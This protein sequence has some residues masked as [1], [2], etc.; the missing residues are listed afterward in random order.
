MSCCGQCGVSSVSDSSLFQLVLVLKVYSCPQM[1]SLSIN[2]RVL[3]LSPVTSGAIPPFFV[4]FGFLCCRTL[5]CLIS[6]LTRGGNSGHLFRLTV[7]WR[8]RDPEDKHRW[9]VWGR[10]RCSQ[11]VDH[12]GLPQSKVVCP[13]CVHTAQVPGCSARAL[14]RV[15]PVF[16]ALPSC[17]LLRFSGALQKHRPRWAVCF[18]PFP[19]PSRSGNQVSSS[20]QS[21][22]GPESYVPPWSQ[23]PSFPGVPRGHSPRCSMCLL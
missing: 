17:K 22:V 23:P 15:G 18:L 19:G 3:I 21:Q 4:Y 7:Q 1:H 5:Q 9:H 20:A 13:S 16:H 8:G 12:T 10:G 11:W 6:A 14:S 2:F